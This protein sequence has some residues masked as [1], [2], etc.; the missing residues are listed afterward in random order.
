MKN[1][2]VGGAGYFAGWCSWCELCASFTGDSQSRALIVDILHGRI[3]TQ[4]I[5][6]FGFQDLKPVMGFNKC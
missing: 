6:M 4:E 1:S 2:V 3:E 5:L